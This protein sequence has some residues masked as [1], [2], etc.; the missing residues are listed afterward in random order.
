V[1][2]LLT[3]IITVVPITAIIKKL[4]APLTRKKIAKQK[5]YFAEPSGE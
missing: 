4:I 3:L 1:L 2:F 5:A